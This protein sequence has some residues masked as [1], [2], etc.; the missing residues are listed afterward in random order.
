MA[1]AHIK[2]H[3]NSYSVTEVNC[4][5]NYTFIDYKRIFN[6]LQ[7]LFPPIIILIDT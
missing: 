1:G 4:Y 3:Q 5:L 7:T 2:K 6:V